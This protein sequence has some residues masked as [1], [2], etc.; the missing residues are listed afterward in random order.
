MPKRIEEGDT[1]YAEGYGECV[2]TQ[3]AQFDSIIEIRLPGGDT[4][5]TDTSLCSRLEA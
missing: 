4:A 2:V 5:W 1:V 3:R